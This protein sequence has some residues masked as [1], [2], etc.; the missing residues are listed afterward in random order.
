MAQ[1]ETEVVYVDE[2]N[3][4]KYINNIAKFVD[5]KNTPNKFIS[6]NVWQPYRSGVRT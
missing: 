6:L 4:A 1:S 3:A 2:L 5:T